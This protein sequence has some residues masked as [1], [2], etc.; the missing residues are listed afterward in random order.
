[1]LHN[2]VLL[3]FDCANSFQRDKGEPGSQK[4][5]GGKLKILK[6]CPDTFRDINLPEVDRLMELPGNCFQSRRSMV[7]AFSCRGFQRFL[8]ALCKLFPQLRSIFPAFSL[9]LVWSVLFSQRGYQGNFTLA[10]HDYKQSWEKPKI[11]S[12]LSS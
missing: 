9:S 2:R 4:L 5:R 6:V 10:S 7:S 11:S 1:M 12:N 8:E 3:Q